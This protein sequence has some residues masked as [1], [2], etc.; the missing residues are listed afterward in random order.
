MAPA[1]K[2]FV[3]PQSSAAGDTMQPGMPMPPQM[4][5]TGAQPSM[6]MG[7]APQG[8]PMQPGQGP[9]GPMP[10]APP[11][12]MQ[13]PAPNAG[14]PT[15]PLNISQ[16]LQ[17][18]MGD[19]SQQPQQ[20]PQ[21]APGGQTMPPWG[22]SGTRPNRVALGAPGG[23]MGLD[24]GMG[25]MGMGAEMGAGAQPGAPGA[26]GPTVMMRLLRTLGRI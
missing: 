8:E 14:G 19:R 15:S 13:P 9:Q 21:G 6:G 5:R 23:D 16:M 7:G 26:M 25:D 17:A 10:G 12:M 24:V 18:R 11:S 20:Q 1:R 4:G 22:D 3:V 2:P